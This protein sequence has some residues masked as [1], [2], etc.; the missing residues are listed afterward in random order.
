M[1]KVIVIGGGIA[2][3]SAGIYARSSGFDVTILESHSIAGGNCT[4]WKRKRY[5][6]E[7]GMHWLSGSSEKDSLHK[8]WRHVGALDDGVKIHYPEPFIEYIH[9]GTPVKFYRDVAVTEKHLISLSPKD[10]KEIKR[11]CKN[12]RRVRNLSMPVT[13]ISGVKATKKMH[14]PITLLFSALSAIYLIKSFSGVSRE[15]YINRFSHEGLRNLIRSCTNDKSGVAP[16]FFTM[17]TLARGDGGFPEGGSLP[18][19]ER[20]VKKYTALGGTILYNTRADRVLV[21]NG[22]ATGVM[23]GGE[24]MP[25][26]AVII[27][28]DTMAIDQLFETPPR[29]VWL[30]EMHKVTEPTMVVL[31]SLGVDA[32]LKNYPR[33]FIFKLDK[34]I[35]LASE[36]YAYLSV[37]NYAH[38]PHYSSEGKTALTIQL[39]GDTYDFWKKAKE[40]NRYKEEKQKLAE[41]VIKALAG[42]ISEIDGRIE[43]CDVATPLTYERYCGNWKGS[44]MTEMTPTMKMKIYPSA[45]KGLS[46]LYFAGQRLMPPGGLPVALLTGRTAVQ[47]LCRDTGTM[48]ISED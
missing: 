28:A 45:M 9:M 13:D 19:V 20:I 17:G 23:A 11:M 36:T 44:W 25:T 35:V 12:I 15:D 8:I 18:F 39:G 38:D 31:I 5:L 4:S 24:R 30:D 6:F 3:L 47:Y 27:S 43:V 7:G 33:A 26:D 22:K 42:H 2:G 10:E 40:E 21:E 32:S 48:F 46:G 37:N 41:E 34:P 1:K 14:P 29:A 16:L